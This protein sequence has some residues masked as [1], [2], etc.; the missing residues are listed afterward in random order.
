MGHYTDESAPKVTEV[1]SVIAIC[2]T[3]PVSTNKMEIIPRLQCLTNNWLANT[4]GLFTGKASQSNL[5]SR[6]LAS[7]LETI[8]LV[9]MVLA[10][11][12]LH[13]HTNTPP[14]TTHPQTHPHTCTCTH[15]PHTH[16]HTCAHTHTGITMVPSLISSILSWGCDP[17]TVHPTDWAV[18]SISFTVPLRCLAMER[19]RIV[20]AMSITWS[21]VM[22]PVCFTVYAC[23][24]D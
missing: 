4:K 15:P 13:R 5:I 3:H 6:K 11:I 24:G 19:E 7:N 12:L 10:F 8:L 14:H 20:R 22:L 2:F 9:Y 23:M 18:P 16:T 1:K 17:S 21:I